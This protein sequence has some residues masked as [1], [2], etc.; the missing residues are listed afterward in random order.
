M[1]NKNLGMSPE[2]NFSSVYFFLTAGIALSVM[3]FLFVPR[4][5]MG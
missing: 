4:I 2:A 1:Q 3:V 5:S